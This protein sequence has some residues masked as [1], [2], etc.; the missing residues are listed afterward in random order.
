MWE[1]LVDELKLPP[2][3]LYFTCF[4][5]NETF[6]IPKDEESAQLWRELFKKKGIEAEIQDFP[7]RDGMKE[8]A[9]IFYYDEKKNWWSRAGVPNNM[10]LGEPGG[11]DTE[12]FFDFGADRKLHENSAW[13][14]EPCHVNCD[15]G[16]FVEIGNNVFMQYKKTE[17]GFE[18][19]AKQNVDF[20]GGLERLAAASNNNPDV[21]TIDL[22][23][24]AKKQIEVLSGKHYGSDE[25]ITHAF[26]VILDHMRAATF[27]IADGVLPGNKD[28]GYFVRRLI[29]RAVRFGRTLDIKENFTHVLAE[30]FIDSYRGVYGEL[31]KLKE[32]I[33]KEC[34]GEETH[35]RL[36]LE[37]GL[38]EFE[39]IEGNTISG[40][41]AFILFSTF[42]FPIEMTEELA[43]EKGKIINIKEYEE[44]LVKHK[45]LSRA[46]SE[47]KFKGGLADTSEM[48]VKYHTA[49]HLLHKALKKVLGEHVQQKGSNITPER[50]R[51]DF[52]H[53]EKMT[54]EQK[55]KVEDLVNEQIKAAL[56]VTFED[57]SKDEAEKRGAIGLFEEKYGDTVRVYKIGDFSLEFCGG[58]HVTNTKDLGKFTIQKEEAVSAGVRRIKAVLV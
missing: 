19:L 11:P 56:P 8:G 21:F 49:T 31:E 55:K 48:S 40:Y 18:K 37:H 46:G 23:D 36:T 6:G 24:T 35:F 9:R 15:C 54:D 50:L 7:E 44:E 29:R 41:Q 28:Q 30:S 10:P 58:P 20:G 32:M 5:G 47:Q 43:K 25:K 52:A 38:K 1:F 16:R 51:F 57:V 3:K 17:T 27:L 22:F 33:M 13:A 2:E 4:R 45:E 14:H 42:G 39:K 53:G 26:R 12:M 34:L